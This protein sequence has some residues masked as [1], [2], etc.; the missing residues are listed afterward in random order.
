MTTKRHL[1]PSDIMPSKKLKKS[2]SD[3]NLPTLNKKQR[4]SSNIK[5]PLRTFKRSYSDSDLLILEKEQLSSSNRKLKRSSSESDVK[6]VNKE[7]YQKISHHEGRINRFSTGYFVTE[8]VLINAISYPEEKLKEIFKNLIDE[9][10]SKS[11]TYGNQ[12][13]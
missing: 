5:I 7:A 12:V 13:R 9:A 4:F 8:F 3:S 11:N 2:S 10:Y 1:S 6:N